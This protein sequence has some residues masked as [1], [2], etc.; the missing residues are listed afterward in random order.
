MDVKYVIDLLTVQTVPGLWRLWTL[1]SGDGRGR[2]RPLLAAS[3]TV[4]TIISSISS[5]AWVSSVVSPRSSA[6][7]RL[8]PSAIISATS[9]RPHYITTVGG[10]NH[11]MATSA[12]RKDGG[13][14]SYIDSLPEMLDE[15]LLSK[16]GRVRVI[17]G[18]E[19]RF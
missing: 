10:A 14:P 13:F 7:R 17:M 2:M 3:V 11:L 15:T 16:N 18:N 5:L 19:V 9:R 6:L 1:W 12:V 8:A 4:A